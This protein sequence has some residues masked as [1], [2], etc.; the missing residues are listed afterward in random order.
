MYFIKRETEIPINVHAQLKKVESD[1]IYYTKKKT[2][3]RSHKYSITDYCQIRI[4]YIQ[5]AVKH[6]PFKLIYVLHCNTETE[7]H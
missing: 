3:G 5:K 2:G 1:L 6:T 4:L 7:I